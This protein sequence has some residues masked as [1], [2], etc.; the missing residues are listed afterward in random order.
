MS[1]GKRKGENN[2]KCGNQYLAWADVEAVNFARRLDGQCRQFFDRKP[3][4][5]NR[6]V[7]TKA[8]ASKLGKASWHLMSEEVD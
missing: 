7:A 3:R 8:L 6:I 5:V 1:N 2:G 4:Q